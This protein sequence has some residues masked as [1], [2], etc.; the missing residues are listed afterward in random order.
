MF[1]RHGTTRSPQVRIDPPARPPVTAAAFWA[2]MDLRRPNSSTLFGQRSPLAFMVREGRGGIEATLRHLCR[3][4]LGGSP[5]EKRP[6]Q[7]VASGCA[8]P[9]PVPA[10]EAIARQ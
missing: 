4:A 2:L 9:T 1:V 8:A 3:M 7:P 5:T 6:G 10:P